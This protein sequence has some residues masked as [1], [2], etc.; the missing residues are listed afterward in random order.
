MT[1]LSILGTFFIRIPKT[2]YSVMYPLDTYRD[3]FFAYIREPEGTWWQEAQPV[4]L[5]H[6]SQYLAALVPLV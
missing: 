6:A 5:A 4:P 2:G 1:T 3:T